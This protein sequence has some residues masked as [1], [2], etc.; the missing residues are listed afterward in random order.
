M[1]FRFRVAIT[2][3]Y[4]GLA[5][6]AQSVR[7]KDWSSLCAVVGYTVGLA[8]M[9]FYAVVDYTVG[10]WEGRCLAWTLFYAVVDYTVGT[11]EGRCWAWTLFYA[12]VDYT[13]GTWE[14]RCFAQLSVTQSVRGVGLDVLLRSHRLHSRYLGR[15]SLC[16]VVGYTDGTWGW[17]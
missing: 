4:L 7:G 15:S 10:T 17:P 13:V 12:V 9:L 8:W 1:M 3:W 14:G 2:Q 5:R 11:W 16:T 6:S